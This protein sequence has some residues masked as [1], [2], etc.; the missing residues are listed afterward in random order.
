MSLSAAYYALIAA[1]GLT[2]VF[3]IIDHFVQKQINDT[4]DSHD[5]TFREIEQITFQTLRLRDERAEVQLRYFKIANQSVVL[6]NSDLHVLAWELNRYRLSDA[7][8]SP[9]DAVDG[10]LSL[11]R[12]ELAEHYKMLS[13]TFGKQSKELKREFDRTFIRQVHLAQREKRLSRARNY[14]IVFLQISILAF[15]IIDKLPRDGGGG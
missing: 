5:D 12:A 10:V 13:E 15:V 7:L 11:S 6:S 4:G 8:V 9:L 14:L 2:A 3:F 1:S